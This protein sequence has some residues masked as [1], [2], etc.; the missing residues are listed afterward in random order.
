MAVLA[1]TTALKV[2]QTDVV[3]KLIAADT[4]ALT[5]T[6]LLSPEQEL[7]GGG[8]PAVNITGL[9]WAGGAGDEITITRNSVVVA[10]LQANAAGF[11]D[12]GG[13]MMPPDN[14]NNTH[15]IVVTMSAPAQLWIRLRKVDGY[16]TTSGEGI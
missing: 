4:V 6:I 15:P 13:Q 2:T 8:T 16:Q 1:T 10:V 9:S 5:E 12:F 3:L 7:I 14:S 11:L